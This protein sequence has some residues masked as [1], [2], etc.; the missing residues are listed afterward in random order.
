MITRGEYI[1][2]PDLHDL[3]YL[4]IATEVGVGPPEDMVAAA[5]EALAKNDIH[6]NS[7]PLCKWDA[8]AMSLILYRGP[9]LGRAFGKRG[10]QVSLGGV[11]CMLKA[12]TRYHARK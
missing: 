8:W 5:R 12:I 3:Y 4:E 9:E 6:L 11:V 7:I 10:D 1:R 2:N